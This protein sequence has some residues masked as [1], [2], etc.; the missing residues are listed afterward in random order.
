MRSFVSCGSIVVPEESAAAR[1]L[2]PDLPDAVL[3]LEVGLLL[4]APDPSGFSF[5]PAFAA[6]FVIRLADCGAAPAVELA[7]ISA[8]RTETEILILTLLL[9]Y[10]TTI[11]NGVK[12]IFY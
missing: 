4:R 8:A 6:L 5:G 10:Y 11:S 3:D 7:A 9:I 2:L 1:T 12:A